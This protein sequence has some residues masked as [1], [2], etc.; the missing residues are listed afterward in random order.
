MRALF[1]SLLITLAVSVGAI[2]AGPPPAQAAGAYCPAKIAALDGVALAERS[3]AAMQLL[4]EK[5]GC[6]V[7]IEPVPGRRGVAH[8]NSGAVDG[9][10]YRLAIIEPAYTVPFV[11]ST[12]PLMV[13]EKAL[14]SAPGAKGDETALYGYVFGIKWHEDFVGHARE[15]TRRFRKYDT[16]TDMFTAYQAGEIKGFLSIKQTVDQLLWVGR[17]TAAP[18]KVLTVARKPLYHYLNAKYRPFM[19]ALSAALAR[20]NPFTALE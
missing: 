6:P 5:L 7:E 1:F 13:M 16:E 4:Y 8:F 3:A 11:R 18:E 9:E 14:W 10:L 17:I 19:E 20:D 2:A 12:V 15:R